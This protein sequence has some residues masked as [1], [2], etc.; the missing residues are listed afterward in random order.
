MKTIH[1]Q[2][3]SHELL[4]KGAL[5]DVR[6]P[7]EF[8]GIHA[9]GAINISL[10]ACSP[11]QIH[12][13]VAVD[14]IE[15][16]Y[17]ICQSGARARM[18]YEKLIASES[19]ASDL[20]GKLVVVD[21]GTTAWREAGRELVQGQ[22]VISVERQV[23]I[24]AGLLITAGVALGYFVHTGFLGISAFVGIGL[25]F[26]GVTD[27]CGMGLVL[28]RMPWNTQARQCCA[29]GSAATNNTNNACTKE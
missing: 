20:T 8:A 2:E 6:S 23:R 11:E 10:D 17:L 24:I 29:S 3:L 9:Q 13:Q 21:G 15:Q 16:V 18:A 28:A 1:V 12:A 5:I 27:F 4:Q 19:V 22:G 7:G 25:I 14:D 26:A